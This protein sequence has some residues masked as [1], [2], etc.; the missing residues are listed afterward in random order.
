MRAISRRHGCQP[1]SVMRR[2][3]RVEDLRE[4]PAFDAWLQVLETKW[5]PGSMINKEALEAAGVEPTVLKGVAAP[6]RWTEERLDKLVGL[7][8]VMDQD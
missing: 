5:Q 3:N 4:D 7:K 6:P 2:V 1:S 8:R